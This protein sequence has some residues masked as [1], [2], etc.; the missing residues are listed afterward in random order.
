ML[1]EGRTLATVE[2]DI[3][4]VLAKLEYGIY[5]VSMGSGPTGN[6]FTAS[7]LTQVSSEP[8]MI[9]VAIHNQHRSA[10]LLNERDGFVVNLLGRGAEGVAK[11]FYGPAEAG[12]DRLKDVATS[13]AP[14]TGCPIIPGAIG[15][16]DCR[17]VK[18]VPCGDH[19]AF[20]GEVLAAELSGDTEILT[21]TSTRLRYGG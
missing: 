3:R 7:W 20:F 14:K 18:R 21:S 12:H 6:A 8:P 13:P 10:R 17:I 9:V 11:T 16:L 2:R 1:Y 5:V 4:K 19:T 15:F